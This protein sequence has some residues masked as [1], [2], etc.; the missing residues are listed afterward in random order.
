MV[1]RH[2]P[3]ANR[4]D[5]GR[6][7]NS[8][9][10]EGGREGL[11]PDFEKRETM[12]KVYEPWPPGLDKADFGVKRF[13]RIGRRRHRSWIS[14]LMR[15]HDEDDGLFTAAINSGRERISPTRVS[16][17][18]HTYTH[19]YITR[20]RWPTRYHDGRRLSILFD[21]LLKLSLFERAKSSKKT[22]FVLPFRPSTTPVL[23][24][25]WTFRRLNSIV[26]EE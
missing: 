19:V 17:Q 26:A 3:V 4:I 24:K 13:T 16:T 11:S 22:G 8:E 25:T 7:Y 1:S 14:A 5:P 15:I 18:S 10:G 6:I 12:G 9:R 20:A 2:G 21:T 23:D